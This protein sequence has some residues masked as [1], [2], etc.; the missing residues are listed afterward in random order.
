MYEYVYVV[1][2]YIFRNFG[3]TRVRT[4]STGRP[5]ADEED[6]PSVFVTELRK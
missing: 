5:E 3:T 6:R 2:I 1:Y 4:M